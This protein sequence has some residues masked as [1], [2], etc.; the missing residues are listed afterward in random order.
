MLHIHVNHSQL[1]SVPKG[2]FPFTWRKWKF[3]MKNEK[4]RTVSPWKLQKIN[5]GSQYAF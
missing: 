2:Y 4:V 1:N 5:M 3:G